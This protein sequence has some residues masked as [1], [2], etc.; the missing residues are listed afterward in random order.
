MLTEVIKPDFEPC[1]FRSSLS[2]LF[3][4]QSPSCTHF[5]P[6]LF[7]ILALSLLTLLVPNMT[8]E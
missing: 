1:A 5:L 6:K 3:D 8:A 4:H 7:T 2:S